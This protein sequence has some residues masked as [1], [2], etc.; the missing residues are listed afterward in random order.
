MLKHVTKLILIFCLNPIAYSQ[1]EVVESKS[2]GITRDLESNKYG[3]IGLKGDTLV[4]FDYESLPN[5]ISDRMVAKKNGKYG[6]INGKNEILIQF[7]YDHIYT[8]YPY[9]VTV[10]KQSSD[11]KFDICSVVDT[12]LKTII[13]E[14]EGYGKI[15]P[16]TGILG[17][18]GYKEKN[19]SFN[20]YDLKNRKV[21]LLDN[22][23]KR[24]RTFP[25][26]AVVPLDKY[27]RAIIHRP[28]EFDDLEGLIDWE[29]KVLLKPEY[30]FIFWIHKDKVCVKQDVD[31]SNAQILDLKTQE[32]IV[33]KYPMVQKPDENGCMIIGKYENGNDFRGIISSEYE[34][35][36]PMCNCTIDYLQNNKKYEI[37]RNETKEVEYVFCN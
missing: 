5:T 12:S 21:S 25:F 1:V 29:G 16:I 7:I 37:T 4:P 6:M 34:L 19:L 30:R 27:L 14:N 26:D 20:G 36:Y 15:Q 17:D 9:F 13:S 23:G 24:Y 8:Y 18:G 31:Y 33:D 11:S 2:A 10:R 35:I 22:E 28:T 3:I 32:V